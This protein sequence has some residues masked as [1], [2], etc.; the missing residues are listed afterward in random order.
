MLQ[1]AR[2]LARY[3]FLWP[4]LKITQKSTDVFSKT[5]VDVYSID[6]KDNWLN[7]QFCHLFQIFKH[8]V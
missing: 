8:L 5:W 2:M 1:C 7:Q 3:H 4:F 6:T